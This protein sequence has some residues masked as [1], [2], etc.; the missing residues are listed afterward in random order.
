[1]TEVACTHRELKQQEG[2]VE[3]RGVGGTS[4]NTF[5]TARITKANNGVQ[6]RKLMLTFAKRTTG[7]L[8]APPTNFSTTPLDPFTNPLLVLR[9]R[10][11]M[12]FQQQHNSITEGRSGRGEGAAA[13]ARVQIQPPSASRQSKDKGKGNGKGRGKSIWEHEKA[14]EGKQTGQAV[15]SSRDMVVGLTSSMTRALA[16][17]QRCAASG[18]EASFANCPKSPSPLPIPAH[19]RCVP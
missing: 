14:A 6:K 7:S 15:L 12:T 16:L 10:I 18:R 13:Q 8:K 19:A 5:P 11:N 9:V 1:M 4:I 3:Y 17:R 2:Y